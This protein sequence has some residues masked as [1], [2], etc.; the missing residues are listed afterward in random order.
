LDFLTYLL[1]LALGGLIIGGLARLLV[2]GRDPMSLFGTMALGIA[3]ALI[4]GVLA[5]IVFGDENGAGFLLSL[6]VAI[7]IVI[8][9]RPS[10]EATVIESPR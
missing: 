3:A 9:L 2:P 7:V 10:R 5:R 1:F 6:A 4:A 8:A